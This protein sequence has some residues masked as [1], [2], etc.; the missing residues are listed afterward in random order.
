ML[1][2]EFFTSSGPD[3]ESLKLEFV[4]LQRNMLEN[5]LDKGFQGHGE[6]TT[7]LSTWEP[8]TNKQTNWFDSEWMFGIKEGFDILLANPPY[9]DSERMVESDPE[10]RELIKSEYESTKGNWDLYIPFIELALKIL[11][12]VNINR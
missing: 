7:K 9:L 1:R 4:N 11:D 5:M 2:E 12:N 6:L 8:F 10:G 3:K